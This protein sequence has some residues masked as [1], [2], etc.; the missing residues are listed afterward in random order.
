MNFSKISF[1]SSFS[2]FC[3]S[4]SCLTMCLPSN[5]EYVLP[6]LKSRS[7]GEML[8][9]HSSSR[10]PLLSTSLSDALVDD[11]HRQHL[12]E[13]LALAFTLVA[14]VLIISLQRHFDEFRL[15]VRVKSPQL[16]RHHNGRAAPPREISIQNRSIFAIYLFRTMC[17]TSFS[18]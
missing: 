3:R 8:P 1:S 4:S 13:R 6:F 17:T 18:W 7:Q 15:R 10:I 5:S 16:L 14:F 2:R 12:A 9:Y 11:H